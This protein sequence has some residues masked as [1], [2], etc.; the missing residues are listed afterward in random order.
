MSR[1]RRSSPRRRDH[2]AHQMTEAQMVACIPAGGVSAQQV[3][4]V[5][6][7]TVTTGLNKNVLV[8]RQVVSTPIRKLMEA[9][10]ITS[11]EFG[12]AV[13]WREDYEQAFLTSRNPLEC[14]QVDGERGGGDINAAMFHKSLCEIR[15][16]EIKDALSPSAARLLCAI[17]LEDPDAG[18]GATFTAIGAE[19]R[20][21]ISARQ[22][23]EAGKG[24]AV[25]AL[26][27]LTQ[28]YVRHCLGKTQRR[29]LTP[30]DPHA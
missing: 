24:R 14:V 30:R 13:R 19:I 21:G 28:L 25:E 29:D 20:P 17:V 1:R 2:A 6:I 12:A 8:T 9:G 7:E 26:R 10:L 4:R 23:Q 11:T 27:Q 18:V 16:Y 5:E 22:Q 15:F 3:A